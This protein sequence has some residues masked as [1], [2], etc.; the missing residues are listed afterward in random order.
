M[1]PSVEDVRSNPNR[2]VWDLRTAAPEVDSSWSLI[3]WHLDGSPISRV[4]GVCESSSH[5]TDWGADPEGRKELPLSQKQ[6]T[7]GDEP[8]HPGLHVTP[9]DGTS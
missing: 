2:D 8:N 1:V 5:E 3:D 6:P 4:W 9:F 7:G